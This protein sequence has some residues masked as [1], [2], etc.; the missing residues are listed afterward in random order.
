M[1]DPDPFLAGLSREI[2]SDET[3]P[4]RRR[5]DAAHYSNGFAHFRDAI[6]DERGRAHLPE[7]I[8]SFPMMYGLIATL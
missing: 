1:P 4:A 8:P 7:G 5:G 6:F 3:R 2:T